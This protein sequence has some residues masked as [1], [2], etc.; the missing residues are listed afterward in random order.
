M[1]TPH[2]WSDIGLIGYKYPKK[3]LIKRDKPKKI[4]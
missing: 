2:N 3:A 4:V 1:M